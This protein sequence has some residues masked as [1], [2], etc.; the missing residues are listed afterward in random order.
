MYILSVKGN[1]DNGAYAVE[2]EEGEKVLFLFEEEDDALRYAIMMSLSEKEYPQLHVIHVEDNVAIDACESYDY[3]YV[4]ISS[5]DLLIP[6]NYD[7][8]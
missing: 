4:V 8:I 6:K 7:K 2:N 1:G 5:N 3:P